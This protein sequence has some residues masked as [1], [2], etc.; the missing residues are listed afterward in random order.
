[1]PTVICELIHKEKRTFSFLTSQE[2]NIKYGAYKTKE[3][4]S[5]LVA[6]YYPPRL[7]IRKILEYNYAGSV[8]T[9]QNILIKYKNLY[10]DQKN[11]NGQ[12]S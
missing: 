8:T 6:T 2:K 9:Y 10:L 4:E 3:N 5:S 11:Y 7:Q 12:Y 1:M